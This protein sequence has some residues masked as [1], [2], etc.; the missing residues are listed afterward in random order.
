MRRQLNE[1][2]D[3]QNEVVTCCDLLPVLCSKMV[4]Y[5]VWRA[6]VTD[7]GLVRIQ[8]YKYDDPL[9]EEV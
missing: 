9:T 8:L 7:R 2:D 3:N 5:Q 1:T 6:T 4:C